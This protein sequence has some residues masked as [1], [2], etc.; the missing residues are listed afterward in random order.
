M[1]KLIRIKRKASPL[2]AG[3]LLLP[4]ELG[5]AGER[6][7]F[8][9]K[10]SDDNDSKGIVPLRILTELDRAASEDII[11]SSLNKIESE[12]NTLKVKVNSPE[13]A[14]STI[15]TPHLASNSADGVLEL[16]ANHVDFKPKDSSADYTLRL[17]VP[18]SSSHSLTVNSSGTIA[19]TAYAD[20]KASSTLSSAKSYSDAHRVA[21]R[22]YSTQDVA[23]GDIVSIS[24]PA[25]DCWLQISGGSQSYLEIA[26]FTGGSYLS[27]SSVAILNS[28]TLY[29]TLDSGYIYIHWVD[30]PF[31]TGWGHISVFS[32]SFNQ[33][34]EGSCRALYIDNDRESTS[35]VTIN[36]KGIA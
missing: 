30:N 18:T 11:I 35:Y 25:N 6:I 28:A 26:S 8:G 34:Y 15:Y 23:Y 33:L 32:N 4:G 31:L 36:K 7:Y 9:K 10:T 22:S 24:F 1:A 21:M 3:D 20:N 12:V 13:Q 16:D 14:Y 5:I 19:T 2:E 29:Q 27:G 17:T